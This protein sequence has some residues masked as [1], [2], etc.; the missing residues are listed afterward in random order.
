MRLT[1]L[2]IGTAALVAG[3]YSATHSIE[4]TAVAPYGNTVTTDCG[5]AFDQRPARSFF[6]EL[7]E[8]CASAMGSWPAV[9]VLLFAVAA[10]FLIR[11]LYMMIGPKAQ[12]A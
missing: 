8:S 7:A 10:L 12:P 5:S 1:M 11:F 3:I 2:L 4:A 6:P 9:S